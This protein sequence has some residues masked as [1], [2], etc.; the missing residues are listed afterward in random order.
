MKRV[1]FLILL[2][3]QVCIA[4]AFSRERA[5][6]VERLPSIISEY[7]IY[8]GFDVVKVGSVGTSLLKAIGGI[9]A[10]V[11]KDE[12]IA[13]V[14]KMAKGIKRIAVVDFEDAAEKQKKSF[15]SKVSRALSSSELLF[16]AKDGSDRVDVYGITSDRDGSVTDIV[17]FCPDDGA[18]ICFFGTI[19]LDGVP[20]LKISQ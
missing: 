16:S 10:I 11:D 1:A 7:S 3:L 13:R 9:S 19:S 17:M 14:L 20:G 6:S 5:S 12:D 4:P 2:S 15:T 8:D 18:L